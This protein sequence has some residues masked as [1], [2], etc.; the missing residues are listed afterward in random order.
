D[1]MVLVARSGAGFSPQSL[2]D[3]LHAVSPLLVVEPLQPLAD[4]VRSASARPRLL[5]AVVGFFGGATLL[6][7][8]IG[9][10]SLLAFLVDER[11]R[12]LSVRVALGARPRAAAGLVMR[13]GLRQVGLG[14][15][16]GLAAALLLGGSL[17]A[18]LATITRVPLS[19]PWVLLSAVAVLAA[20]ALLA[21]SLPARR[22]ARS[23]PAV[24]LRS[25]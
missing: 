7:A 14:A 9:L 15:A 10:Y 24:A 2:R 11:R 5:A 13:D 17:A 23:D 22:A 19:D 16:I 18:R 8:A 4:V 12:E 1:S 3:R 6:L 21:S 25:E 20:A